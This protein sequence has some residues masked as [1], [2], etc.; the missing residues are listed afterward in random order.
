MSGDGIAK[1]C[2]YEVVWRLG[3]E[4]GARFVGFVRRSGAEANG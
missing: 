1:E 3:H 2:K 4:I